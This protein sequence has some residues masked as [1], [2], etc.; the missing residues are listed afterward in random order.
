MDVVIPLGA[1]SIHQNV[2]LRFALRS[3]EKYVLHDKVVIIGEKPPFLKNVI[4]IRAN[5]IS[6]PSAKER[7]IFRK[8][9]EAISD[10][11]VSENFMFAND[12]HYL[13]KKWKN[14]NLFWG[15]IE[16]KL[17]ARTGHQPYKITVANTLKVAP[18]L[19]WDIHCPIVYNKHRF[20]ETV[21]RLRW[22]TPWGFA[23]K[24]AYANLNGLD[25]IQQKDLKISKPLSEAE[26]WTML[27][28]RTFFSSGNTINN[29]LLKV[30]NSLYPQKSNYEH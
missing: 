1:G 26:I 29:A 22:Q 11:R 23:I 21:G 10:D 27:E 7:N 6:G 12:D 25:G 9:L 19:W 14:E 2:E 5:D 16:Q 20:L 17:N 15:T 13:L 24:S 3:I 30:L 4:H 28:N 8:I 18:G